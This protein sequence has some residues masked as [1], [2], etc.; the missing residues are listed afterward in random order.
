[1]QY[2]VC[3]PRRAY[4]VCCLPY[5]NFVQRDFECCLLAQN[6]RNCFQSSCDHPPKYVRRTAVARTR[7]T[8]PAAAS[9]SESEPVLT[10]RSAVAGWG[11]PGGAELVLALSQFSFAACSFWKSSFVPPLSG[12]TFNASRLYAVSPAW[13]A[14]P[15]LTWTDGDT[16]GGGKGQQYFHKRALGQSQKRARH[17]SL[18]ASLVSRFGFI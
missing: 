6:C 14:V 10:T 4:V 15:R 12:C 2:N 9:L 18:W 11:R 8:S 7:W 16:V 1:M 5:L 3:A 13:S 17:R